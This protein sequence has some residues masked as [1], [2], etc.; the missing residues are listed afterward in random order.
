[1]YF[2]VINLG[3]CIVLYSATCARLQQLQ[4]V[5]SHSSLT[6]DAIWERNYSVVGRLII[7]KIHTL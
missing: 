6:I 2:S 1:M 3:A 7:R 5:M 4:L